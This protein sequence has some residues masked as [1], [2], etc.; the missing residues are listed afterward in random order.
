[1]AQRLPRR[2]GQGFQFLALS[3]DAGL[4][5]VGARAA[6]GAVDFSGQSGEVAVEG[7]NLYA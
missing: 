7:A 6:F 5:G 3:S 1:M 2:I 4:L